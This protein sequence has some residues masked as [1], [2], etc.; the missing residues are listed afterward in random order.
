[1]RG[2]A[3]I[4]LHT[5]K[6]FFDLRMRNLDLSQFGDCL[7]LA[8]VEL[9]VSPCSLFAKKRCK[10]GGSVGELVHSLNATWKSAPC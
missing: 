8:R 1:M 4:A 2:R 10:L 6:K 5:A 7:D 3:S 9:A